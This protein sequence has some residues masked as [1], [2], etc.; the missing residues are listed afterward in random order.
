[1]SLPISPEELYSTL[2]KFHLQDLFS[3]PEGTFPIPFSNVSVILPYIS[4]IGKVLRI[5]GSLQF[6]I[7]LRSIR[8]KQLKDVWEYYAGRK[9]TC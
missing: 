3:L 8:I 9:K 5:F 2:L 4:E 7:F 6:K 1:M